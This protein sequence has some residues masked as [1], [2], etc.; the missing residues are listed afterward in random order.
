MKEH[1]T[2]NRT[3]GDIRRVY[4]NA[5]KMLDAKASQE[6]AA[7][8]ILWRERR[9]IQAA[10]KKFD[11]QS[12]GESELTQPLSELEEGRNDT[13]FAMEPED[14]TF[15]DLLFA[16]SKLHYEPQEELVGE[17]AVETTKEHSRFGE[18]FKKVTDPLKPITKKVTQVA[19]DAYSKF[20]STRSADYKDAVKTAAAMTASFG[21]AVGVLAGAFVDINPM[22]H[23]IY[24]TVRDVAGGYLTHV[25]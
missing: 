22:L 17:Y 23:S 7:A 20:W 16:P 2:T 19:K 24:T 10:I 21:V 13:L 4:R 11:R 1:E 9:T 25:R 18:V 15:F 3:G 12:L 8:D 14:L 5:Q 6:K